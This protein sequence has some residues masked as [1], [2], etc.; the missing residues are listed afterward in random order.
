MHA[1]N[2]FPLYWRLCFP[3]WSMNLLGCRDMTKEI[4]FQKKCNC[5]K[6]PSLGIS[7][8]NQFYL[9]TEKTLKQSP[10]PDRLF[11]FPLWATLRD[12]PRRLYVH[13]KTTFVQS[14]L[15]N[16]SMELRGTLSQ[17]IVIW[18][19]SF[20]LKIICYLSKILYK[21]LLP[22]PLRRG[23][24]RLNYLP[25]LWMSHLQDSKVHAC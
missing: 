22:T 20:H 11:I 24:L 1:C 19:H 17:A 14:D 4:S 18:A 21:P 3:L 5:L 23:Y 15:L 6:T 7:S 13:N 10:L 25:L 16:S 2:P 9:T 12:Y 8:N